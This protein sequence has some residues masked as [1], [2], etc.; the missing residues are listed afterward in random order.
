MCE[1]WNNPSHTSFVEG[2][3]W[4]AHLPSTKAMGSIPAPLESQH[5]GGGLEDQESEV[6]LGLRMI[7]QTTQ[8]WAI[9]AVLSQVSLDPVLGQAQG[10]LRKFLDATGDLT[11]EVSLHPNQPGSRKQ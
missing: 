8:V 6:I 5:S 11:Q 7:A 2:A 9:L 10:P 1:T 3:Q 4:M